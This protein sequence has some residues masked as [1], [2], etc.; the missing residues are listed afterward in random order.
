[1]DK[2][3][4]L[5][6]FLGDRTPRHVPLV[7]PKPRR[8][9]PWRENDR[10]IVAK[11]TAEGDIRDS[12][13]QVL[14]R[15]GGLNRAI[16]RGNRVLVK[17]NF[18]SPDPFPGSTDLPFLRTVVQILLEAG[19]SVTIGESSG[20]VWRPSRKVF[21]KVGLYE[22]GHTLGVDV[23]AFEDNPKD[24]VRVKIKGDYLDSVTMPRA[25]YEADKLVYLPCMK[26]HSMSAYTGA[27]KLAFGFVHPGE[28]RAY[29]MGHLQEKLAEVSLCWQPD[30]ILM[31]GRKAFVSGGPDTGE[32]V[33]PGLLL[34][35]GDLIAI[36]VEALKVLLSYKARNRL[37]PDPWQLP[38]IASALKHGLGAGEGGYILLG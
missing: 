20:G 21:R 25:A 11:V 22:L 32:L 12:T 9:N 36:D 29:H 13:E 24:W 2:I 27:L 19:A 7:E 4:G 15:L 23:I 37:P 10:V 34:A 35:S 31:D 3:V 17:P 1:M 14:A 6:H 18:N 38:Q 33:E 5:C 26:T 28:R 16:G 30:L 8:P